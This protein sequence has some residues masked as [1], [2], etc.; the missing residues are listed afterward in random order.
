MKKDLIIGCLDKIKGSMKVLVSLG[1]II[2]VVIIVAYMTFIKIY[3]AIKGR[4]SIE[5]KH[6]FIYKLLIGIEILLV[7]IGVLIPKINGDNYLLKGM[8][9]GAYC[10]IMPETF[11]VAYKESNRNYNNRI[12]LQQEELNN[13]QAICSADEGKVFL[14]ITQE[15]VQTIVDITNVEIPLDLSQYKEGNISFTL[16]N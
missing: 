7:L 11:K 10:V 8:S 3:L 6:K 5:K 9:K 2:G 15:D 1:P 4:D 14:R 12:Y 16:I 13:V